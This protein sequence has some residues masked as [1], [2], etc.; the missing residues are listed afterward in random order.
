MALSAEKL[1]EAKQEAVDLLEYSITV[2]ASSL[3]VNLNSLSH[4]YVH[5]AQ[6]GDTNYDSHEALKKQVANL[7]ALNQA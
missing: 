4:P 7:A 1:A 2:L 5:D 3:G 6:E